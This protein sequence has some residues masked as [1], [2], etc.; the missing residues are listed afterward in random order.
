[1]SDA[2][3]AK[4]ACPH[5]QPQLKPGCCAGS[6][7]SPAALPALPDDWLGAALGWYPVEL[8]PSTCSSYCC[9]RVASPASQDTLLWHAWLAAPSLHVGPR[10][11]ASICERFK[12]STQA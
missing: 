10:P 3:M 5:L 6:C 2:F 1:M 7:G 8:L 9:S 12:S 4:M 11:G